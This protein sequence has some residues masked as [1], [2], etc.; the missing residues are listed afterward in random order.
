VTRAPSK[1]IAKKTSVLRGM[2]YWAMNIGVFPL[3]LNWSC[4]SALI[5]TAQHPTLEWDTTVTGYLVATSI[6]ISPKIV[7][8][9]RSDPHDRA[10]AVVMVAKS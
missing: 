2:V 4:P 10:S 9:P 3:A 8:V 5:V 6:S 7:K 1:V